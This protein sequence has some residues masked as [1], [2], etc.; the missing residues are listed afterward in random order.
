MVPR[1]D[2][3]AGGKSELVEKRQMPMTLIQAGK[4]EIPARD[5]DNGGY[6]LGLHAYQAFSQKKLNDTSYRQCALHC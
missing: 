6:L 5:R 4:K 3:K 2:A 1:A